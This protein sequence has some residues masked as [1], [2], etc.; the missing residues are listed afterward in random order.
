MKKKDSSAPDSGKRT[1]KE[2]L[3]RA[4]AYCSRRETSSSQ[5]R[6]KL[7]EWEVPE[8]LREAVLK[9]L[10][11]RRFVDDR[12]FAEL[13]A[14][15]KFSLNRWGRIKIAYM[16]RQHGIGEEYIQK[17]LESIDEE[18]YER[19]CRELITARSSRIKEKNPYA[20]KS[21]LYR[22]ASGRGFEPDLIYKILSREL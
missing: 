16:L 6:G 21:K 20:R 2:A 19:V 10:T 13:F 8:E 4:A 18:S 9:E 14:R 17:A 3:E 15:E 5:L 12:R 1:F 7:K 11:G 22:Y